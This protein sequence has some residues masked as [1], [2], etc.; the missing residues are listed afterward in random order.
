VGVAKGKKISRINPYKQVSAVRPSMSKTIDV[1]SLSYKIE[2]VRIIIRVHKMLDKVR[3]VKT[4]P[5]AEFPA[6][7]F[8]SIRKI[9]SSICGSKLK[10][11]EIKNITKKFIKKF[12]KYID[13]SK[14]EYNIGNLKI[15]KEKLEEIKDFFKQ[16]IPL[17]DNDINERL[18]RVLYSNVISYAYYLKKREGEERIVAPEGIPL[19]SSYIKIELLPKSLNAINYSAFRK[20]KRIIDLLTKNK[21]LFIT[22]QIYEKALEKSKKE[23]K[24]S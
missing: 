7:D 2:G 16:N 13:L 21:N 10:K 6:D 12:A 23:L 15:K 3:N 17:I 8:Y 14:Y 4:V 5:I 18:I 19:N 1:D 11:N 9:I 20:P 22:N 24:S